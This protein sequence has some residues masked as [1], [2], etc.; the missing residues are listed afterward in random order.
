[1]KKR[2]DANIIQDKKSKIPIAGL[3]EINSD[4]HLQS[5]RKHPARKQSEELC[6][7]L[8]TERRI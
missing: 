3:S 7:D 4:Q 6:G 1:M 2:S 5:L 8:K